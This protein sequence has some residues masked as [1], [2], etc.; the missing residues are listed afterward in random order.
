MPS[1]AFASAVH[2]PVD[3]WHVPATLQLADAGEQVT[4]AHKALVSACAIACNSATRCTRSCAE[5]VL[6]D[7]KPPKAWSKY[8]NPITQEPVPLS[9]C[10][11][12]AP[13]SS[14]NPVYTNSSRVV[15]LKALLHDDVP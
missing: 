12:G 6:W 4:P 14:C 11:A 15:K 8:I 10:L 13:L 5:P 1:A 9:G 7:A 3:G 2:W